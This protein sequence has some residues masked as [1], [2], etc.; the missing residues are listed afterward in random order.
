MYAEGKKTILGKGLLL[1]ACR[2]QFEH[3]KKKKPIDIKIKP[4]KK[5]MKVMCKYFSA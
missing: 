3:P 1:C 2:I 5:F 4:P